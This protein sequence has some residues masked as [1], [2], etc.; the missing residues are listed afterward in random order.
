MCSCKTLCV[1]V[2]TLVSSGLL[3]KG[4]AAKTV[5]S[6]AIMTHALV[7]ISI[8]HKHICIIVFFSNFPLH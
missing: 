8:H 5:H 6:E 4:Q 2:D 3:E 7:L 1:P